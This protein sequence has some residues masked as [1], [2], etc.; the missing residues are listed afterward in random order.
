MFLMPFWRKP[1]MLSA[2]IQRL[3]A[4]HGFNEKEGKKGRNETQVLGSGKGKRRNRG[5]AAKAPHDADVQL[6]A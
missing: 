2:G 6:K 5:V 4:N 1:A 3:K